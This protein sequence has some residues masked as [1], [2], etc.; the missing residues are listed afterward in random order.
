MRFFRDLGVN[1]RRTPFPLS[2]LSLRHAALPSFPSPGKSFSFKIVHYSTV[3]NQTG[4]ELSL[5][6]AWNKLFPALV[7]CATYESS[8]SPSSSSAVR[9]ANSFRMAVKI[10]AET[11]YSNVGS[12]LTYRY[13]TLLLFNAG[14]SNE[15]FFSLHKRVITHSLPSDAHRKAL[16]DRSQNLRNYGQRALTFMHARCTKQK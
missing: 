7:L 1:L 12:L 2:G 3:H 10:S 9:F 15:S 6:F 5:T 13:R 4:D 11:I 16:K 8:F 14:T